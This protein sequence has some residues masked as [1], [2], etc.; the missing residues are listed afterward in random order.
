MRGKPSFIWACEKFTDY[1]IGKD[2]ELETNHKPLVPLLGKTNLDCL[3]PIVLRF[4]IRLMRFSYTIRHVAG[5]H[6]YTADTLSRAPI[7]APDSKHIEEDRRTELFVAEIVSLL[8]SNADCLH[9]YHSAQQNDST[10]SELI[11]CPSQDGRART[12]SLEPSCHT[13][14]CEEN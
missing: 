4:R 14:Q 1:V 11:A 7:V 6:L 12:N 2:I 5:K 13:G 3:Q 8:P 9:K 10:C